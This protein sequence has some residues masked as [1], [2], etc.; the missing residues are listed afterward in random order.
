MTPHFKISKYHTRSDPNTHLAED[1][2]KPVLI[3]QHR[4]LLS[5]AP[6]NEMLH[7]FRLADLRA[8]PGRDLRDVLDACHGD[9][10]FL[11]R[12]GDTFVV[13]THKVRRREVTVSGVR[14][15]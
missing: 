4:H 6:P 13:D 11:Y 15:R 10:S 7:R 12:K 1:K 3:L 8:M 9:V 5:R 2:K 14:K